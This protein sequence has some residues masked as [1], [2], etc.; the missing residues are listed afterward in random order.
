MDMKRFAT[1]LAILP[2]LAV[3]LI[4]VASAQDAAPVTGKWNVT[5]SM[6][7]QKITEQWIIAPSGDNLTATI[8]GPDGEMKVPCEQNGFT[9]RSDFKNSGGDVI[10]VRA[11]LGDDRMDGSIRIGDKEYLW[12]AKRAKT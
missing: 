1:T 10:K 7:G 9:F 2:I 6:R 5:I 12:F 8:K 3:V 4:Q 11:G